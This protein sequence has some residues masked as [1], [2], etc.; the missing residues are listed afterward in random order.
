MTATDAS[1]RQRILRALAQAIARDGYANTKVQAVAR[2]AQVSLRTFYA[3][4]E[5]KEAGFLV[6]QYELLENLAIAVE[7]SVTFDRPWREV[8]RRGF[9]L[10]FRVL[11]AEPRLT[12]A[13]VHELTTMSDDGSAARDWARNRFG[14]MLISLVDQGREL[15]PE[16]RSRPLSLLMAHGILGAIMELVTS[17]L[18]TG[19]AT[20]DDAVD[21]ATDLLW[22]VITNVE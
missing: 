2:D 18:R 13:I 14:E 6:L 16:I 5:S 20:M 8:I 11:A 12:D 15:H 3:E 17:Q 4:F 19:G 10:Y 1:T 21:T 9:E 22:S 7:T